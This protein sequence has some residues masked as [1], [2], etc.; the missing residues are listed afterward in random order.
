MRPSPCFAA[1]AFAALAVPLA[2]AQAPRET[3][4]LELGG[5]QVAVEYGSPPW[6]E[7]RRSQ[8]DQMLPVGALWRLGADTRTTLVV[9]GS[10]VLIGDAVIEAG[11][12]GLNLR[13][14]GEKEWAFVVFD[15]TDTT[16]QRDDAVFETPA[17]LEE[18]DDA[19]PERLVV[20]FRDAG[21]R[22]ALVVRWGPLELAAPVAA[23]ETRESS[24][25]LG[26]EEASAR[27]FARKAGDAPRPGA[28][29]RAGSIGSFYVG[30]ADC[31]MEVDLKVDGNSARVRFTNRERGR[32]AD[33]LGRVE[34]ELAQAKTGAAAQGTLGARM[35]QRIKS[36]EQ[37]KARYD[38]ELAALAANPAPLEVEVPL[39]PAKP[40][41]GRFGAE[42]VQ[43][44]G[45]LLVVVETF[46]R[47]GEAPVDATK[48]LPAAPPPEGD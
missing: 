46:D 24:L 16:V 45:K 37:A 25:E 32:V 11:G 7:S 3:A 29:T 33:R 12:Y 13:R 1:L 36:L 8:I 18:K 42:L 27:W 47:S 4:E 6:S 20:E 10:P 35:A 26:G 40:A 23:L 30:D 5:A 28:W 14:T 15:G 31:A 21:E 17:R 43:R 2:T 38:E 22:K 34:R 41:P 48:L 19:A 9:T 44:G 39:K